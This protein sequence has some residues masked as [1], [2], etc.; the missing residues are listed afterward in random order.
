MC[1]RDRSEGCALIA[2][3]SP[4]DPVEYNGNHYSVAQCNNIYIFPG[5]GLG[6]LASDAERVSDGMLDAAVKTLAMASPAIM[7]PEAALLPELN[8]IHQVT[9]E[10][11]IAVERKAQEEGLSPKCEQTTFDA[12]VRDNLSLIHI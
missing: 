5:L 2:T 6:V 3:G 9:G 4:F 10:I 11:A 1:I 8:R 12:R 7:N